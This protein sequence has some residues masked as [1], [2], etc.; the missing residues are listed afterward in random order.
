L[1]TH[2]S[3]VAIQNFVE[4]NRPKV[5]S[6]VDVQVLLHDPV[7]FWLTLAV[8]SPIVGGLREELWRSSFLAGLR[9]LWPRAF[10]SSRG[11]I[12]G[13]GVAALFFGMGHYPQGMLAVAMITIVGFLLGVIMTLHRSMWPSAVAHALFDVT[14]VAMMPLA[15]KH[16]IH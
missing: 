16:L 12:A 14:S 13:A 1:A 15:L 4:A 7:Y 9:A 2:P 6:L 10:A 8:V 11:G 5:E 3:T